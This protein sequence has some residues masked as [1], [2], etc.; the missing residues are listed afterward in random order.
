MVETYPRCRLRVLTAR[1]RSD[2]HSLTSP[3]VI[4]S[5]R[6]SPN[7]S[8]NLAAVSR[9]AS[10]CRME[11]SWAPNRRICSARMRST[12]SFP[13]GAE[14]R[15]NSF[16]KTAMSDSELAVV[17][18]PSSQLQPSSRMPAHQP[19]KSSTSFLRSRSATLT[20]EPHIIARLSSFWSGIHDDGKDVDIRS[21]AKSFDRPPESFA[22]RG[23]F[24]TTGIMFSL[25]RP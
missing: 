1:G 23:L 21:C 10:T 18:Q 22:W 13:D 19:G 5:M 2:S 17:S 6:V 3:A 14:G 15:P 16:K 9:T 11:I 7:R 25:R 4:W 20:P 24:I 12:N 8:R